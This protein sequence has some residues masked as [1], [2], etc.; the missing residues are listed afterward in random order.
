MSGKRDE[1]EDIDEIEL[2]LLENEQYEVK[3]FLWPFIKI[4]YLSIQTIAPFDASKG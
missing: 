4:S 1:I 2:D 3:Y